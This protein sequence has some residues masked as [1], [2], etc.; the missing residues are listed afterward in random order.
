MG[1]LLHFS[2]KPASLRTLIE[3]DS[4]AC[5]VSFTASFSLCALYSS[6]SM[7]SWSS[8]VCIVLFII[9]AFTVEITR[10]CVPRVGIFSQ[11]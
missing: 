3:A 4:A 10:N 5:T 9:V 2:L 7:A 1:F 11:T 6:I 8:S